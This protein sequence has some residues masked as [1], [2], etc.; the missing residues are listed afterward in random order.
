MVIRRK[1][2]QHGAKL[3]EIRNRIRIPARPAMPS[4]DDEPVPIIDCHVHWWQLPRPAAE[5][6]PGGGAWPLPWLEG[7]PLNRDQSPAMYEAAVGGMDVRAA[8]F[9]ETNAEPEHRRTEAAAALAACHTGGLL[10]GAIIGCEI[11]QDPAAFAAYVSEFAADPALKGVRE[12]LF[13]R[14]DGYCRVPS[15]V[16]NVRFLGE[17]GLIFELLTQPERLDDAA[18]LAERAPGT[19]FVLEHC[20]GH[21][22]LKGTDGAGEP[23]A[24]QRE[25]WEHGI[26]ALGKMPNVVVKISA[27]YGPRTAPTPRS[28]PASD[29]PRADASLLGARSRQ[30]RRLVGRDAEG[31]RVEHRA[32]A[33]HD[34]ARA[35]RVPARASSLR[36]RLARLRGLGAGGA[37]HRG[38]QA[39]RHRRDR[40][41]GSARTLL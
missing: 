22:G 9:V 33:R 13:L 20:G 15:A 31:G 19:T 38:G 4:P 18:W 5:E 10:R 36:F 34:A 27:M 32:A 21:Q 26:E 1:G 14:P 40:H 12:V 23:D 29:G 30:V 16:T 28:P 37:L 2:A 6:Q 11:T 8:V 17:R 41:R 25:A 24:A 7:S 39:A 35:A 3:R